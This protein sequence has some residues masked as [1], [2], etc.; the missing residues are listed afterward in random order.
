[1]SLLHASHFLHAVRL[2]RDRIPSMDTY[3]YRIPAVAQLE[4]VEFHPA[5]TFLMGDN[6]SG[7]ST[8]VEALATALGMNGEG[9]SRYLQF[10]THQNVSPLH[11]ALRLIRPP[12]TPRDHYFLRAESLFNVAT[13]IEHLP[14]GLRSYGG[15][16]LHAQSHGESFL[17]LVRNRFGPRGLYILDEP[18]AALS[19]TRQLQLLVLIDKLVKGGSQFIIATHSPILSAYENA[20]IYVLDESGIHQTPWEETETVAVT[21]LFLANPKGRLAQ[22]FRARDDAQAEESDEEEE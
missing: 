9:G 3:P 22:L 17:A 10:S 19:P 12:T 1:M 13:Q 20:R 11:G 6:G 4:S 16:S 2:M 15:R 18:E 14:G 5:V 7:K 21:R 8:I